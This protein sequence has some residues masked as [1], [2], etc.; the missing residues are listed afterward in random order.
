MRPTSI[1]WFQTEFSAWVRNCERCEAI[2]TVMSGVTA[3]SLGEGRQGKARVIAAQ[4]HSLAVFRTAQVVF[5]D[6]GGIAASLTIRT[7]DYK[8]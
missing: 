3:D 6:G 1:V 4:I 8:H 7:A 2:K 5:V